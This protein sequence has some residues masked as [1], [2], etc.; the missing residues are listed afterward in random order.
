M[1][2]PPYANQTLPSFAFAYT[3]TTFPLTPVVTAY[4][5]AP[6]NQMMLC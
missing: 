6:N 5:R 3:K 2:D 4:K 1:A